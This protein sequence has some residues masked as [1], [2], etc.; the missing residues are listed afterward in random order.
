MKTYL[1]CVPCFFRQALESSRRSGAS[2]KTQKKVLDALVKTIPEISLK[3]SPPEMARVI[4]QQLRRI[5]KKKDPYLKIKRQSN[6]IALGI[7]GKLKRRVTNS[8]N[9]LLTAVELAIAGNIIDYGAKNSL[10]IE[11]ELARIL[12]E[13]NK[14]IRE[15][16]KVIFDY[17]KFRSNLQRAETIL[18]LADNAGETVF[19]RILIEEIKRADSN[20]K[21]IYAVKESP[22]I[23]D[24]LKEDAVACGLDKV[25]QV[26]SSG[27]DAPGTILS[28][29]SKNFLKI[30]RKADMVISKGQGNFE[31]LSPPRRP[32]FFMFMVK[33]AVIAK[34]AGCNMGNI[35]LLYRTPKGKAGSESVRHKKISRKSITAKV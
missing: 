12:N 8:R 32:V 28:L 21:I 9:K 34:V 1:D 25:A 31:A 10:N 33:C 20:K 14:V 18:Y 16:S 26:I 13:E 5:T 11:A 19:D 17:D 4:H 30:Y 6:K 22:A 7:Y 24:A 29:C 2:K 3:S 35:V 15:E 27:S 23:N